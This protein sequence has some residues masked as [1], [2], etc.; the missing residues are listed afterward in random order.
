MKLELKTN[1][2]LELDTKLELARLG[3]NFDFLNY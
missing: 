1:R 2:Q 3:S